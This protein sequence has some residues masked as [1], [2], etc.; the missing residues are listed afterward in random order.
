MKVKNPDDVIFVMV[1]YL[2]IP[3]TI[4]EMKTRPTQNAVRQ[5]NSFGIQT[6]FIIARSAVP[7]DEKRKEKLAINCNVKKENVISAPDIKSIYDVPLNFEKDKIGEMIAKSLKLTVR[8]PDLK[9]WSHF[10]AKTKNG[11]GEVK[12]AIIGKYFDTGDFVLSDS[13]LSVI[14]S[15]KFSSFYLNKRANITWLNSKDFEKIQN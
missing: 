15:I 11:D 2:P 13:Y 14:E 3:G 4:G 9:D 10:V 12:I 8:K 1:S 5:L 6:D 7:M